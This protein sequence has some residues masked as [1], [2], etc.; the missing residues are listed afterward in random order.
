MNRKPFLTIGI[1][2]YN[3]AD[4]LLE[5]FEQIKKQAFTDYELLYCDDGSTDGSVDIIEKIIQ[6]NPDMPIR[7]I[8][9]ENRGVLANRNR[10]LDHAEGEYLLICDADD[11]MA[12]NCLEL[13][14]SKAIE[15]EADCVIGGFCEIDRNGKE[16]KFHIPQFDS[17]KWIFIWHH[18]QM[19]RL[20][21]VRNYN[22]WFESIPDDVCFLQRV[23]QYAEKVAYVSEKVYYWCRHMDSTSGN[24]EKNTEWHP[25]NLWKNI[26]D[27]ILNVQKDI[28]GSGEL[29]AIRYFLYKWFYF[30]VTDLPVQNKIELRNQMS[31]LQM[32]MK[33]ICPEYRR[34]FFLKRVLKE[35]DTF[36]AKTAIVLCWTLEGLGCIRVLPIIRSVQRSMHK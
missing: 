26:V 23:H 3:Y 7:L 17:N 32:D 2:S 15:Q 27:C 11:Y 22:L 28:Q 5:A 24:I 31:A 9:G 34:L 35:K 16:Y 30:N 29:W 13:L 6:D 8:K 21:L 12:D 4:C 20:D 18:A 1:A 33:R 14:C 10:I 25:N 19:Y 36:F